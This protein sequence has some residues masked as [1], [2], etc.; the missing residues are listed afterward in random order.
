MLEWIALIIYIPLAFLGATAIIDMLYPQGKLA[1][2]MDR[3]IRK[4]SQDRQKKFIEWQKA[5]LKLAIY[6]IEK[7]K[8]G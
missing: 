2:M 3:T 7:E 5:K 6:E 4:D 1:I 8:R